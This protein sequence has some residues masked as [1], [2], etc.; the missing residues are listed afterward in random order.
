[1]KFF[2]HLKWKVMKTARIG[3]MISNLLRNHSENF[4][5]QREKVLSVTLHRVNQQINR[6]TVPFI[7]WNL[8]M[9]ILHFWMNGKFLCSD[10]KSKTSKL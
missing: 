7:A 1:M 4:D 3:S 8:Q 2:Y 10:L 6:N 9:R 5:T